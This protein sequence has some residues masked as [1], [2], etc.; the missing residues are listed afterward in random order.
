[1]ENFVYQI[2]NLYEDEE[3]EKVSKFLA[4]NGLLYEEDVDFTMVYL[5][6]DEVVAT[7]SLSHNIIK[8]V[9][10]SPKFR[11][12]GLL[13]KIMTKLVTMLY[14]KGY[15][16]HFIFTKPRYVR[17]FN[18]YG[19]H[20]VIRA[21]PY[22]AL[23]EHGIQENIYRYVKKLKE[24][25]VPGKNI[26]A[27]IV[28]CNPVTYDHMYAITLA[29]SFCDWLH[30]FLVSEPKYFFPLEVRLDL[31]KKSIAGL[32]NITIHPGGEYLVSH[33]TFPKYFLGKEK[34]MKAHALL[35]STLF[36]KHIVP[37]LNINH[38]YIRR[39]PNSEIDGVYNNAVKAILPEYGV[40]V[41]EI[42]NLVIDNHFMSAE[43]LR[44]LVYQERWDDIA[45]IVTPETYDFLRS[46]TDDAELILARMRFGKDPYIRL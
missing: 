26:G 6:D 29:S 34:A 32:K 7:G 25:L 33:L 4:S 43:L 46:R 28:D 10:V 30:L 41:Q 39:E 21:E 9:A 31:L 8:C 1:M 22:V 19:F 3:K 45:K 11:G 24:H 27:M 13:V 2:I 35:S 18:S 12:S 36:G 17:S 40:E 5:L 14:K 15:T 20:E 44:K 16:H 38:R 23:L 37:A 42:D